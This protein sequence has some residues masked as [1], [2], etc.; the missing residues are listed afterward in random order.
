MQVTQEQI[1]PCEIELQIEVEAEK[2]DSAIEESYREFARV[3]TV[4]GFRKGKAPRV[5]L[6]RYINEEKVKEHAADK[7]IRPAYTQAL[8]DAKIDPFAP[9][10]VEMVKFERGE[11][12]V[13]KAKVPLPPVIELGEYVGLNV[14][15]KV[16]PVTDE[17]V[18]KEVTSW[19]E[20]YAEYTDVT[21]RPVQEGDTILVELKNEN[22]PDREPTRNVAEVG[23]NL[24]DFDKGV[25]GMQVG[26]EKV[27]EIT[28]PEDFDA[29]ELRGQ[30]IPFKVTVVEIHEK[31]IPELTDEWVKDK[32]APKTEE[33]EEP[34]ADV[35]DSV[36]KLRAR[37]RSAMEK[38]AQDVA[39]MEVRNDLMKKIIENSKV[40]FPDVMVQEKVAERFH[41]LTD[42]LKRRKVT[43]DEYLAHTNTTLQDLREQYEEEA[44]RTLTSAL[45]LRE[46]ID[47]QGIEVQ[48]E[49][50]EAEIKSMADDRGV[51]VET[52]KAYIEATE[53]DQGI[54]NRILHKK[55]M[56]FLVNASNIKTSSAKAKA[57]K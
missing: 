54:R 21:D 18:D 2:V 19:L 12:L 44:R 52:M 29:E 45:V 3:T 20:R 56:D 42:E 33:G 13:F 37:V 35:V 39:D 15:R 48:E 11:P 40:N 6:E 1:N 47:K 14:T 46:V 38:A 10:D 57:K 8:E 41:D 34:P 24:P 30:T 26:E 49:D 31:K 43:L 55:V 9:A 25:V 22:E 16:T 36:E 28:Y 51:P 23:K 50:V 53:G 17:Q 32:F 27:I 7:L 4:P 5:I